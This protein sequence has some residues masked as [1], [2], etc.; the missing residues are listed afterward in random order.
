[1][2][3]R[4]RVLLAVGLI[5]ATA[6]SGN[7]LGAAKSGADSCDRVP[8]GVDTSDYFL[9]FTVP[10]GLMPDTRFD[11]RPARIRVHRVQPVYQRGKCSEIAARAAVLIHGRT[12]SG[13]DT[14][15]LRHP[16]PGG[17]TLSAQEGLA[18]AGIDSFA[19]N[20]LGYSPSTTFHDGLDDPGNASRRPYEADG[21]TCLHPE[22][23][24]RTHNPIFPLDQQGTQLAVNPLGG[25]RQTHTSDVR[26]ASTDVWVR[27]IRQVIDDAIARAQPTDGKVTLVGYSLGANR[28]GR[29]LYAAN[30]NP[31]L[32][33][34]A[35]VIAKVN[36]VVF[37]APFFGGPTEETTPPGGFV[38][39]PLTVVSPGE[40][41]A[42]PPEREA[43]CTGRVIT[44]APEQLAAQALDQDSLGR[45]WGG[46][47][48]DHRT[49]LRRLPT[50]STY[51]W[52]AAVAGQLAPPTLVIQGLDDVPATVPGG[53]VDAPAV[54]NALP[55]SMTNKVLVQVGCGSH[56]FLL[57]GCAGARCKPATGT[58]YGEAA[59]QP[60]SGPHTTFK[61]ALIEWI[62]RGTFNGASIGKF[63]VD[64]SGVVSANP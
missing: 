59:D 51:G 3:R 48:P 16:A 29:T 31:V 18:R 36:R 46:D 1:M 52:N 12:G 60:W 41:S 44:G 24:D 55:A 27:D 43:V 34:S 4:W 64:D 57:E 32:A 11:R 54:Y 63:R 19:P 62:T 9:D 45:D 28:V 42:V 2:T 39:F 14:F 7:L 15:D 8:T 61:A 50:F 6:A 22:G 56:R 26:F 10:P 21:T 37:A 58:A 5:T 17:G 38:T 47:P 30:P 23:C 40:W 53:A 49:G 13:A 35:A 25:Q 20:L 33:G